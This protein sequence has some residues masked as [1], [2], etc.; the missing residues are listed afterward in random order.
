MMVDIVLAGL[1]LSALVSAEFPDFFLD[2]FCQHW[3]LLNFQI[4]YW[5]G[6]VSIGLC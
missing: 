6:F 1:V 5:T 4:S 3:P 2:W